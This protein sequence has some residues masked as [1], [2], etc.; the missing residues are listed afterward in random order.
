MKRLAVLFPDA[1]MLVGLRRQEKLL[2]SFYR[3]HSKIGSLEL[4]YQDW[5]VGQRDNWTRPIF[6]FLEFDV[7]LNLCCSTFGRDH[8]YA[9]DFAGLSDARV[10]RDLEGWVQGALGEPSISLANAL[11]SQQENIDY[12]RPPRLIRAFKKAVGSVPGSSWASS[13]LK[14]SIKSRLYG[15][16]DISLTATDKEWLA[17]RFQ[18][19]NE[20]LKK[21]YGIELQ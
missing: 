16:H 18:E 19:S 2:E 11:I 21:D 7:L 17:L 15:A 13:K 4:S 9:F 5:L 8:V 3:Q 12:G 20:R 6:D 14:G 1:N 10:R